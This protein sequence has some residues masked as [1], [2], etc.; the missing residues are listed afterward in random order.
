[1]SEAPIARWSVVLHIATGQEI[2]DVY[3]A[4][5]ADTVSRMVRLR[6]V[7]WRTVDHSAMVGRLSAAPVS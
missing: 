2:G 3:L 7:R 4:A 1:M 5:A 6:P